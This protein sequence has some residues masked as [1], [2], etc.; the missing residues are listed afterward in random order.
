MHSVNNPIFVHREI[1]AQVGNLTLN[2]KVALNNR[3]LTLLIVLHFLIKRYCQIPQGSS[4]CLGFNL[5]KLLG[6]SKLQ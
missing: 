3:L 1:Q 5:W 6:V 4:V 2:R